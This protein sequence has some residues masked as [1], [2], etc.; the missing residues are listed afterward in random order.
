MDRQIVLLQQDQNG[1]RQEYIDYL[2]GASILSIVLFHLTWCYMHA[3]PSAVQTVTGIFSHATRLFFFCSGFGLYYS[4]LRHPLSYPVFLRRRMLKVY[5]PYIAVIVVCAFVP[6]T[7]AYDDRF[8]A[9]LSHVFLYK[10]FIPRYIQTFG[11]FWFMSSIFQYYLLFYLLIRMKEKLDNDRM[12]ALIWAA[13]SLAYCILGWRIPAIEQTL[14]WVYGA[15]I[16]MHGWAFVLGMLTAQKLYRSRMVSISVKQ[17]L[18]GFAVSVPVYLMIRMTSPIMN[19]IPRAVLLMCV[20]T[21][22]W[23]FCGS[24]LRRFFAWLGTFSFEWYLLHMLLLEA[25]FRKAHP[26]HLADQCVVGAAGLLLT[27]FAAWAYHRLIVLIEKRN[28]SRTVR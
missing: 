1:G 24:A 13:V 27:G 14:G 5:L 12:F 23:A 11:P 21:G 25:V 20:L 9:F 3:V 18:T 28:R 19:E 2:K 22:F 10:M 7:Y 26:Q 6:F 17:L 16:L 4:H 15:C 8:S